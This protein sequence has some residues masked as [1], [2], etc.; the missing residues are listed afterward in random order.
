MTCVADTPRPADVVRPTNRWYRSSSDGKGG[1]RSR[2]GVGHRHRL[3]AQLRLHPHPPLAA[4]HSRVRRGRLHLRAASH[5]RDHLGGGTPL[6]ARPRGAPF[7]RRQVAAPYRGDL[8]PGRHRGAGSSGGIGH[9]PDRGALLERTGAGR[10]L[11]LGRPHLRR[12]DRGRLLPG[13]AP[14]S[15][16]C[17]AESGRGRC[18]GRGGSR[19][20]GPRRRGRRGDRRVC[21]RRGSGGGGRVG[22]DGT[23]RESDMGRA[24]RAQTVGPHPR[25]DGHPG[26]R[27]GPRQHGRGDRELDPRSATRARDLSGRQHPRSGAGLRRR[28]SLDRRLPEDDR[29]RWSPSDADSRQSDLVHAAVRADHP[30]RGHPSGVGRR[31]ALSC[32]A[33]GTWARSSPGRRWQAW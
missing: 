8:L 9:V 26:G 29:G 1:R 24:G 6:G 32:R 23:R 3:A 7:P 21:A 25:S 17:V 4:P 13:S 2:G 19:T 20:G 28:R 15:P 11:L 22:D 16:D 5:L 31:D 10:G 30:H 18:Q 12:R 33:M 27:G 14:F